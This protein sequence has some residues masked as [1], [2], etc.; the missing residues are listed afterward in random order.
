MMDYELLNIGD[1]VLTIT[2]EFIAIEN[3]D[4]SVKFYPLSLKHNKI[5]LDTAAVTTIGHF[6]DNASDVSNEYVT[7][8]GVH[9]VNF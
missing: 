3:K 9:I 8:N 4:G 7:E 2:N 5:Y 6:H 1:R